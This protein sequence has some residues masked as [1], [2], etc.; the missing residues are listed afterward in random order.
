[1]EAV[2]CDPDTI[3]FYRELSSPEGLSHTRIQEA[4]QQACA[5]FAQLE[6]HLQ[7]HEWLA[8]PEFSL[9]DISWVVNVY[10][11]QILRFPSSAYPSVGI[12]KTRIMQRPSFAT[13]IRKWEPALLRYFAP[14]YTYYR[15]VKGTGISDAIT[16]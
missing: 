6:A 11:L 8:G 9:A 15:H 3:A 16:S 4:V 5:S 7:T 12:W 14:F 2:K 10:R 13:A 1:M